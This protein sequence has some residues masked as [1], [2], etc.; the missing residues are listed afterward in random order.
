[1]SE[2]DLTTPEAI[3]AIVNDPKVAVMW[4][5]LQEV[6]TA[7]AGGAYAGGPDV[8]RV[9]ETMAH[10]KWVAAIREAIGQM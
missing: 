7:R 5:V 1:M 2:I 6:R 10:A 8:G 9:A 4:R 3:D